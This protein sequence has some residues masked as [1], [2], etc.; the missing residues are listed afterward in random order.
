MRVTNLGAP[1]AFDIGCQSPDGESFG[2]SS[3]RS[4]GTYVS[5]PLPYGEVTCTVSTSAGAARGVTRIPQHAPLE[6]ALEPAAT[7]VGRLVDRA[8]AP[9]RNRVVRGT[10]GAGDDIGDLTDEQGAFT[11]ESV[12]PGRATLRIGDATITRTLD[13]V[14]GNRHDLGAIV[15][16]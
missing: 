7:I 16:E 2:T 5:G 10:S 14:G 6:L 15:V 4:D 3:R 8:G 13:L 11:I 9:V 1:T 12:L